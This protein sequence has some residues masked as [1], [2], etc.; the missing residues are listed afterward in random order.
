[1]LADSLSTHA[2]IGVL[3]IDVHLQ[4]A[5]LYEL[6]DFI[7][8]ELPS[9]RDRPELKNISSETELTSKLCGYLNSAARRSAGW[10]FLQFRSEESDEQQKGRKIDLV[11]SPCNAI[12]WVEG[13]RCTDFDTLL[14]IECKRLPTPKDKDRDEREYVISQNSSTGGIQRFKAGHH[15]GNHA[16]A[17]MIAYVQNQ[18]ALI[19]QGRINA[20]INEL[21]SSANSEWSVKDLLQ[22]VPDSKK[23]GLSIYRSAHTRAKGLTDIALT[24]LWIEMD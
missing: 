14:P 13:R 7:A 20:W 2:Q 8:D 1:M 17:A 18:T 19:W 5:S 16:V 12:V 11:A 15:G 22:L 3:D 10:D 4:M 9:W 23:S 6:L 21:A 24:H